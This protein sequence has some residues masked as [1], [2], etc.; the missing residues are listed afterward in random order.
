MHSVISTAT[1]FAGSRAGM[2]QLRKGLEAG[3]SNLTDG[4]STRGLPNTLVGVFESIL[5]PYGC[6]CYF[7]GDHFSTHYGRGEP[8]DEWDSFCKTLEEGYA[9]AAMDAEHFGNSCDAWSSDYIIDERLASL[10]AVQIVPDDAAEYF[11]N[12]CDAS[13]GVCAY[14]SCIIEQNYIYNVMRYLLPFSTGANLL[15]GALDAATESAFFQENGFD[16]V[17]DCP[18]KMGGVTSEKSCCGDFPTRFPFKMLGDERK[19]C[20]NMAGRGVTYNTMRHVCC[21]DGTVASIGTHC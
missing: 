16:Q 15:Q 5:K 14:H 8:V 2:A 21:A 9:C 7:G 19:C 3:I 17:M 20:Q 12:N 4:A 13:S 18:V 10:A 6:W 1:L 11:Q